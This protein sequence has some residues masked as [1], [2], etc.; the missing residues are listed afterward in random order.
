[1]AKKSFKCKLVT[2]VA[3]LLNESVS[4]ASVPA[5]DGLMGFMPG[6]GAFLGRLGL[7]ELRLDIADSD[8]GQGGSR[9]FLI[10]G[11]FVKMADDQMTILADKA[12]AIETLTASDADAEEKVA[13]TQKDPE[14]RANGIKRANK[15]RELIRSSG[16]KI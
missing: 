4:Y 15:M 8:K 14:I 6:R 1:M 12:Y 10:D 3:A 16:G 13:Q 2:P 5:W 7:G 11:G 9:V